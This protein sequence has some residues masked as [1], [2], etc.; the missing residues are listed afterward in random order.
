MKN[1]LFNQYQRTYKNFDRCMK[2]FIDIL[3]FCK[4]KGDYTIAGL[5]EDCLKDLEVQND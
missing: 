4:A 3:I 1:L 2:C 5:I